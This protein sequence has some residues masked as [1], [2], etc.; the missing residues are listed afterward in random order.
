MKL[1]INGFGRIGRAVFKIAIERGIDIVAINDVHGPE[2]AAYLL[3]HDSIYG[4]YSKNVEVN[5]QY[6]VIGN[7]KVRVLSEREPRNLPWKN[8]GVDIVIESTGVFR[9]K[10]QASSH[11]I[12]G[13][14]Y[15]LIT[16]PAENPDITVVPGVNHSKLKKEHKII[17]VASC[18]TNCLVPILKVLNDKFGIKKAFMTTTHAYTSDQNIHDN[19]HKKL[20]RGRA[21]CLNIVPT[22]TGAEESVTE[23]LPELKG[24][25]NGLAVRVPVPVGSLIDLTAVLKSDFDIKKINNALKESSKKE[26][27]GIIE[28]SEEELVST[29]CIGNPHSTIVDGLSTQQNGDMVKVLAWYDNEYGYSCRV[30]DV[31]EM[32]KK[33]TK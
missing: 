30:V 17:S 18:T 25:I 8:L 3:K 7:K 19:F 4:R 9:D 16:S 32:L 24:K 12:T 5:G 29:D 23:V 21:A 6:L 2:D 11:I 1:A 13:A 15:V 14:K 10:E 27:K 26:L 28:Y 31:V 20:R 33:W 22:G